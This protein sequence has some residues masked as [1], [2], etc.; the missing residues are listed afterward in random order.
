MSSTA[1][2][3]PAFPVGPDHIQ[4]GLSL[5]EWFAAMALQGLVAKGLE[6][7]SE[8]VLSPQERDLEMAKRAFRLADAMLIAAAP[9]STA[10]PAKPNRS[11]R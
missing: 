10:Q 3:S 11:A 9:A 2:H 1:P 6:V 7:N 8:R 5:R 4:P